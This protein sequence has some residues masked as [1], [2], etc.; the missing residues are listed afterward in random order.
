MLGFDMGY[1]S[2]GKPADPTLAFAILTPVTAVFAWT[3]TRYTWRTLNDV[4]TLSDTEFTLRRRL[5]KE[6]IRI[7]IDRT[8]TLVTSGS[9]E[10]R[11]IAVTGEGGTAFFTSH[12]YGALELEDRLREIGYCRA[13]TA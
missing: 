11:R 5:T 13:I 8:F 1:R 7:R 12:L 9:L 3:L 6:V 2:K 4:F 10:G